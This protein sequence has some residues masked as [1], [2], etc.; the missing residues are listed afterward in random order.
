MS[1]LIARFISIDPAHT[2]AEAESRR[3][4]RAHDD[5]IV[6]VGTVCLCAF[7]ALCLP[8]VG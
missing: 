3:A 2:D 1:A 8:L 6:F 5:M 7:G 4:R